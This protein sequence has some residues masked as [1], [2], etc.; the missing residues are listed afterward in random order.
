MLTFLMLAACTQAA[1]KS[2]T[3]TGGVPALI[4]KA[5]LSLEYP[6]PWDINSQIAL[7]NDGSRLID[8]SSGARYI[9]VWDWQ[10]NKGHL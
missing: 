9:R 8:A 2:I 1:N 3:N 6:N 10:N 4:P 5:T 7:S